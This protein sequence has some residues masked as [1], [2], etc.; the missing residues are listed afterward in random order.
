[1]LLRI[2]PTWGCTLEFVGYL[3]LA[4]IRTPRR[5]FVTLQQLDIGPMTVA[6]GCGQRLFLLL[7]DDSFPWAHIRESMHACVRCIVRRPT[8]KRNPSTLPSKKKKNPSTH[9]LCLHAVCTDARPCPFYNRGLS[10]D[11][12]NQ[13]HITNTLFIT[14]ITTTSYYIYVWNTTITMDQ[15]FIFETICFTIFMSSVCY[16]KR[17]DFILLFYTPG[18]LCLETCKK[19]YKDE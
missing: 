15:Y 12:N 1:M 19:N 5:I 11:T 10:Y 3:I 14:V 8:T 6:L 4:L 18:Y 7:D 17:I 13:I 2:T 16:S 9:R